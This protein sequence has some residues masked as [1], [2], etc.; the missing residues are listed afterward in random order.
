MSVCLI[1]A[2]HPQNSH[3]RKMSAVSR[4]TKPKYNKVKQGE[5]E[6]LACVCVKSSYFN[7]KKK[8]KFKDEINKALAV[9]S[10]TSLITLALH[11]TRETLSPPIPS[12]VMSIFPAV[13]GFFSL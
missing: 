13:P 2:F 11:D 5:V 3:E 4:H 1:S 10:T 12:H 7:L 8:K 6:R 9:K